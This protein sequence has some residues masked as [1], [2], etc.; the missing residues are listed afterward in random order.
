M[1]ERSPRAM[2][3]D[4]W[5]D[6]AMTSQTGRANRITPSTRTMWAGQSGLSRMLDRS[7]WG[8][9]AIK[10]DPPQSAPRGRRT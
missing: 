6:P 7:E 4:D 9:G 5:V 10:K 8:L 3:S 2:A 1:S